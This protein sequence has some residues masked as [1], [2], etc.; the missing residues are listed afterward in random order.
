MEERSDGKCWRAMMADAPEGRYYE[1][2]CGWVESGKHTEYTQG[3][4]GTRRLRSGRRE[5]ARQSHMLISE[6]VAV[7]YGPVFRAVPFDLH[8]QG[9]SRPTPSS[10][11]RIPRNVCKGQSVCRIR[12]C[13]P[14]TTTPKIGLA[15][16]LG[17]PLTLTRMRR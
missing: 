8:G 6:H 10:T 3:D 14:M 5:D 2:E 11:R 4:I 12:L 7:L 15:K 9:Q 17:W 16:L 1:N 13:G